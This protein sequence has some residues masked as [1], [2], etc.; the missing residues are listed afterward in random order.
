MVYDLVD[1]RKQKCKNFVTGR[2]VLTIKRD[3]DGKFL[4]AKA[5]W[6][7]RGFQDTQKDWQQTDSPTSTRPGF[8]AVCQVAAQHGWDLVHIDLKTAFLQGENYNAE[9][10]VVAQLPPES[11]HPWYMV[12]RLKKPAYGMNDA[13][14]KWRSRLD[15][16]RSV[17][18]RVPCGHN[19]PV[20]VTGRRK[21]KI[22]GE[23]YR[24]YFRAGR[25]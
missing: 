8:R 9:R 14:R 12:A 6:V 15:Q 16:F 3:K 11:G 18:L 13:P 24:L 2:W 1:V 22:Q 21:G 23:R 19:E 7:L 20:S 25:R 4:K 10:D 5:R 17:H